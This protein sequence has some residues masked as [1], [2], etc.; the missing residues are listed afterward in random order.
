MKITNIFLR[1]LIKLHKLS[2]RFITRV[3]TEKYRRELQQCGEDFSITLP[4]ITYG[5]ENIRI[6]N[7]F[8]A[9]D[10]FKLR[11]FSEWLHQKF[12]PSIIIGD[13]FSAESDCYISAINQIQIG[14]DVLLASRVTI[15]DHN[16]GKRD[17]SDL[18]IPPMKRELSSK[19]PIVIEDNVWLGENVTV[20]GGVRIGRNSIVGANSVVTKDIPANSIAAGN[21]AKIIRTIGNGT[22]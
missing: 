19:G 5:L 12:T 14:N 9:G 3:Y 1:I 11:C 8:R 20:L 17:F 13:D 21:P 15:I 4:I 18:E 2:I 10:H 6:G 16:H 7:R 22:V